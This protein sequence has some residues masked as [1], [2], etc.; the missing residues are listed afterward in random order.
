VPAGAPGALPALIFAL[1]AATI[2]NGSIHAILLQEAGTVIGQYK[3][4]SIPLGNYSSTIG[5]MLLKGATKWPDHPMT[6]LRKK[7]ISYEPVPWKN[8][9]K[10]IASIA[11]F[12]HEKGI[13]QGDRVAVFSPN[14]YEMLVWELAVASMGAVS[15]SIFAEYGTQVVDYILQHAEPSAVFVD[16][17]DRLD[18]ILD[19]EV[20]R[21]VSLIV[22]RHKS[23]YVQLD[24]C[25][26]TTSPLEAYRKLLKRV[27]PGD[28]CFMLYTS[29]ATGHP[30]G[31]MLTHENILSQQRA[32][33]KLWKI[34]TESRFLSY[35]PWH[36]SFGGLFERFSALYNGATIYLDDSAHD[37]N[38]DRL[39]RNWMLVKPTQF[40]GVPKTFAALVRE[41]RVNREVKEVLFHPGL[42]FLFT[43]AAPLPKESGEYFKSQDIQVLEG[44]GLTETSPCVT[45]TSPEKERVHSFVGDPIPGCEI[46]TTEEKEILVRG[47]NVMRGYFKDAELTRR[48]IDEYGWFASGDLGEITDYGLR[49]FCRADGMFKLS[50]GEKV[51]S[52]MIENAL[53]HTSPWIEHAI[54]VGSGKDF[55]SALVF[56]D[57]GNLEAW[58]K[59]RQVTLPIGWDLAKHQEVRNL[60]ASD[61]EKSMADFQPKYMEVKAFVVIPADLSLERGELTPSLKIVRHKIIGKY[62]EWVDAIYDPSRHLEKKEFVTFLQREEYPFTW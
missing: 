33:S 22:T 18:K 38:I 52:M 25:R 8:A 47:P 16:G 42:Q 10:D 24:S 37:K 5:S 46:L 30:K 27:K 26:K 61:I 1:F 44:W 23:P 29:G 34:S 45:L 36:H 3:N 49:L 55:V 54:A 20:S 12:L 62:Q 2:E 11:L 21:D 53:T 48:V 6:A 56:P 4:C 7:D 59:R 19:S 28:V 43:A 39:I 17:R 15:V 9:L 60:I 40:F 57:F 50:N 51:S 35:L 41:A 13:K 31:V 14:S 32:L 58:A